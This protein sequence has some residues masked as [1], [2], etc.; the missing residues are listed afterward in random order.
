MSVSIY[1]ESINK[2]VSLFHTQFVLDLFFFSKQFQSHCIY[3]VFSYTNLIKSKSSTDLNPKEE[4]QEE[5]TIDYKV[6]RFLILREKI[7]RVLFVLGTIFLG[8][9][10]LWAN[11]PRSNYAGDKSSERQLS[12]RAIVQGEIFGANV[13]RPIIRG[14]IIRWA[15]IQGAIFRGGAFIRGQF[16]SGAIVLGGNHPGEGVIFLRGNCTGT[17]PAMKVVRQTFDSS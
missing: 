2:S 3:K 11:C 1:W 6:L 16:S 5:A 13:R 8:A 14:T 17:T 7:S 4:K 10:L 12:L 15:I 9:V